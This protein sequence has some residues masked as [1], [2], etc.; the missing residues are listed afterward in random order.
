M[1]EIKLSFIIPFYNIEKF[2]GECLDS[3]YCQSVSEDLFEV[4][5]IDDC[6]PDNSKEIVK[7]FQ[8]K[9]SNL[10]L[11]EHDI[12]KGSGVARNTGILNSTG[13]YIWFIDSDDTIEKNCI[14]EILVALKKEPDT[15]LFNYNIYNH[16]DRSK[17]KQLVFQNSDTYCGYDFCEY[18]FKDSIVYHLG[19]V[20]RMIFRKDFINNNNIRFPNNRCG[21]DTA[22]FIQSI[23]LSDLIVSTENA[24]Y[25]YRI[26]PQS[27][28]G[29]LAS[30][31]KAELFYEF[32]FVSALELNKFNESIRF[33][34][35]NY[36]DTL[37]KQVKKFS[38]QFVFEL[39]K[40]NYIEKVKFFKLIKQK[41]M[42]ISS[43]ITEMNPF[44]RFLCNNPN[45]G[46]FIVTLIS[47]LYQL[48]RKMQ[49][50]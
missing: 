15:L 22:F 10:R 6:S 29:I 7:Q 9:H 34:Y 26:N 30:K 41:K 5:C 47:P 40:T 14:E 17:I 18:Y 21:E 12:N 31:R 38:N 3:I 4:I 48:K 46:L 16:I 50:K 1:S 35:P 19:Y 24:Y 8:K 42:D 25:N 44:N 20:W 27:L 23:L 11:I 28:S 49:Q 39:L 32:A 43:L 45:L 36:Y 37:K 13:E 33:V 2:I